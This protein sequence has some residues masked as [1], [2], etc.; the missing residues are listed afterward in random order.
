MTVIRLKQFSSEFRST[1][2]R[3][4]RIWNIA[5]PIASPLATL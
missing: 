1:T 4:A 5:K 2:K 3:D